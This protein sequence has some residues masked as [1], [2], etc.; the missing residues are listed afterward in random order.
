M[1]DEYIELVKYNLEM[2]SPV[3]I[4]ISGEIKENKNMLFKKKFALGAVEFITLDKNKAFDMFIELSNKNPNKNYAAYSVNYDEV[5][6]EESCYPGI[7][8]YSEDI[9]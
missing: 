3:K 2:D 6:T 7:E 8:I 4:I 9:K 1:S 5:L